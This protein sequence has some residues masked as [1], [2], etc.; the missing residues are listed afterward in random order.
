[1]SGKNKRVHNPKY[2]L[3]ANPYNNRYQNCT[4]HTLNVINAAIYET[5]DMQ[6][7]K[8]NTLA[9]FDAQPVRVSRF[10]LF[11]GGAFSNGITLADHDKKI[12]T[13]S[14]NSIKRYLEKYNLVKVSRV[15]QA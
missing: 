15:Y 11:L 3:I 12:E 7:L 8:Q 14:F 5:T 2:S 1:M 6:R 13:T 9:Y 4:E 10:K